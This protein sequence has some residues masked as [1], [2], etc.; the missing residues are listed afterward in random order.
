[1]LN[2][3]EHHWGHTL[4]GPA[5]AV[6]PLVM[7]GRLSAMHATVLGGTL[8]FINSYARHPETMLQLPSVA[9]LQRMSV[10]TALGAA[11]GGAVAVLL[12]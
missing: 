10:H 4:A 7:Y 9:K 3:P 2:T 1:M 11:A 12:T 6:T 5:L 8:G